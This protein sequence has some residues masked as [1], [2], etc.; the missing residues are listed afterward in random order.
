M[1]VKVAVDDFGS[2]YSSIAYLDW[3]P[4]DVVKLDRRFLL[5]D[6]DTRRL[7]LLTATVGLVRSVGALALVE[8]VETQ[9]QLE[10]VR[11]AG[12]DLAQGY[13]FGRPQLGER[14]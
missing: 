9:E 10:I 1:G 12:A 7:S 5:G 14:V 2:G 13:F 3:I 8:G 6:L 4:A 11:A